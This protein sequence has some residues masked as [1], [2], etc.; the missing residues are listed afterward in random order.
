MADLP[1]VL[2][3]TLALRLSK[4]FGISNW[5]SCVWGSGKG[6]G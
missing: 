4:N 3:V 6:C 5:S 1:L 2:L